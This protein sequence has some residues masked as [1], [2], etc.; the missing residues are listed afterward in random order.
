M[1]VHRAVA[2]FSASALLGLLG[3]AQASNFAPAAT[4]NIPKV[5]VESGLRE[6]VQRADVHGCGG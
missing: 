1:N 4:K 2:V 3:I 6:K 5:I